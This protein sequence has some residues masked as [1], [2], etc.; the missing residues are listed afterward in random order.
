MQSGR[1]WLLRPVL[2][3]LCKYEALH[4]CSIDLYDI[5]EMNDAIDVE[6]ENKFR[7]N[8]FAQRRHG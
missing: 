6:I 1:D 7:L 8:E 5:A 3:G 4:D 2:R